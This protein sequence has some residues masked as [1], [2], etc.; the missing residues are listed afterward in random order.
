MRYSIELRDWIFVPHNR[1][2]SFAKN[3]G[4]NVKKKCG[5]HSKELLDHHKQFPTDTL[6]TTSKTINQKTAE[7]I[8]NLVVNK[9]ADKIKRTAS[10]KRASQ[11]HGKLL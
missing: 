2:W 10:L 7:T 6:K 1:F 11:T 5:K 9:I 4:K 3:L 8:D